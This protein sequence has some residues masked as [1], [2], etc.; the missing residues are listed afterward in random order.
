MSPLYKIRLA[1]A[2]D[3]EAIRAI[4]NDVIQHSTAMWTT[5][6]LTPEDGNHE[7]AISPSG[8]FFVDTYS[9]PDVPG[10]TVLRDENGKKLQMIAKEDIARLLAAGWKPPVPITVKARDR[11]TDLYGLMF[12]PTNLD[13]SRK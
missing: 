4:R 6:L 1:D 3:S 11:V 2:V 12:E 13:P 5:H 8:R 9:R 7:V 10:V